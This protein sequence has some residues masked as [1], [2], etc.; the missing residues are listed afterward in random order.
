MRKSF[1]RRSLLTFSIASALAATGVARAV[2]ILDC[3]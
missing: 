2:D 3:H 1:L